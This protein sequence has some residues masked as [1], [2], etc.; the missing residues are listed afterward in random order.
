MVSWRQ[1]NSKKTT[2]IITVITNNNEA[3]SNRSNHHNTIGVY[4]NKQTLLTFNASRLQANIIPMTKASGLFSTPQGDDNQPGAGAEC[5]IRYELPAK[6][7]R[8]PLGILSTMNFCTADTKQ[9]PFNR[10]NAWCSQG[11]TLKIE[12]TSGS[13]RLK[14]P[15]HP[16]SSQDAV[17]F[18]TPTAAVRSKGVEDSFWNLRKC[19]RL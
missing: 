4:T 1:H 5:H 14:E 16:K 12:T 11:T 15:L 3:S 7:Q 19:W 2:E 8:S 18:P 6:L 10:P 9:V 13:I 17:D